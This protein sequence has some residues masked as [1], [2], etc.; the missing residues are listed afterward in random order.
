[1]AIYLH[2]L[3]RELRESV[4]YRGDGQPLVDV[5][6]TIALMTSE[7]LYCSL[8]SLFE[9]CLPLRGFP[10]LFASL[11]TDQHIQA[12]SSHPTL[13]EFVESRQEMYRHDAGRYPMYFHPDPGLM[14]RVRVNPH[15]KQ[16]STT[17]Y[18]VHALRCSFDNPDG[19]A[20]HR[21][22]E[23]LRRPVLNGLDSLREKA[24]TFS[25]F[26]DD[27]LRAS[28]RLSG[29]LRRIISS[30]YTSNYLDVMDGDIVTG[31]SGLEY[32][33]SLSR[34][35]PHLD[36]PVLNLLRRLVLDGGRP[37]RKAVGD[38]LAARGATCQQEFCADVSELLDTLMINYAEASLGRKGPARTK[39]TTALVRRNFPDRSPVTT[40]QQ[41]SEQVLL[42][43]EAIAKEDDRVRES[44]RMAQAIRKNKGS[45]I[46]IC[47][48]TDLEDDVLQER[49]SRYGLSPRAFVREKGAYLKLGRIGYCE[50]FGV[51]SRM[52][53]S[54]SNAAELTTLDAIDELKPDYVVSYGIA[55]GKGGQQKIGDVLVSEWVR[56]YEKQRVGSDSVVPRGDR[57]P[58]SAVLLQLAS[59]TRAG[60]A[61]AAI[62]VGGLLSGEKL[63]DNAKL[64]AQLWEIEPEAIGGDME[65]A[66]IVSACQRRNRQWVVVK[67]ICDW[68][69]NKND[70]SRS[71]AEDQLL[72]ARNALEV[73]MR[74]LQNG[75]LAPA[76]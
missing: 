72:A 29:E 19:L 10:E 73:V 22:A 74:M 68:G 45:R 67:A 58:A 63:V 69:E 26:Q 4:G 53:T 24:V 51:R 20:I 39:L 12:L 48:A 41:A 30:F 15:H 70:P 64:K 6:E 71:K 47:T 9:T 13:S 65:G 40:F 27:S 54:G 52:G 76:R 14:D 35:F 43:G 34:R 32:F 5:L 46:L 8:S 66:G 37:V 62:K 2:F 18:L 23:A 42:L 17:Q 33:D 44:R 36:Y 7:P 55:F 1:M 61:E 57:V 16:A 56:F 38:L 49:A 28:Q 11:Y 59:I 50:L 21:P 75:V 31:V 60:F 3:D 25:A